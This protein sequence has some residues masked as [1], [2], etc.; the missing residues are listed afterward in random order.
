[1]QSVLAGFPRERLAL[2]VCRGNWSKDE[3]VALAGDYTPLLPLFHT[4]PV[5]IFF[6]EL[7]TPRAGEMEVLADLPRDC[8]I[9]VGVANQKLDR[10][11][12]PEEIAARMRRA[13][14]VFG[15]ERV[16]FNPD[17]GFATF[18]DNPVTE[19]EIAEAKLRSI[20]AAV[21]IISREYKLET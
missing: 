8:R 20:G 14:N 12:P 18:A 7:C 2:H 5:G 11:E 15:A 21:R 19:G 9:G 10:I 1:L 17:C 3:R 6:L 4:V 13:I 16:M